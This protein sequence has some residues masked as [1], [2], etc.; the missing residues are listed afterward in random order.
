MFVCLLTLA[1]A[2]PTEAPPPAAPVVQTTTPRK[3]TVPRAPSP[4]EALALRVTL[5]VLPARATVS[6]RTEAGETLGAI[7]PY[8]RAAGAPAGAHLVAIPASLVSDGAIRV[9][10]ELRSAEGARPL[11]PD[12]L[13][14]LTVE[15][16]GV[17]PSPP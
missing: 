13:L 11:G 2:H 5:G 15:M 12:E 16:L 6:V 14:D 8:G 4:G 7:A 17:E 9:V 1:C 10:L 3:V